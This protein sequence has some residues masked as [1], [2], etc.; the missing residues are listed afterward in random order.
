MSKKLLCLKLEPRAPDSYAQDWP[1]T[2]S[3][4]SFE[5]GMTTSSEITL[6]PPLQDGVLDLRK[7]FSLSF[8]MC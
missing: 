4:L 5:T 1:K 6:A 7:L 2:I 8:L 3:T